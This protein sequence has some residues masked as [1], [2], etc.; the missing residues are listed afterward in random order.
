MTTPLIDLALYAPLANF[1]LLVWLAVLI[2]RA[3]RGPADT[4]PGGHAV[5]KQ[6]HL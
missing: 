5:K 1:A 4:S 6:G 3:T 2:M